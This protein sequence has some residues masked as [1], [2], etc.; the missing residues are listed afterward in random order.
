LIIIIILL[1]AFVDMGSTAVP[2][3][4]TD[5]PTDVGK[6]YATLQGTLVSDGSGIHVHCGFDYGLTTA[7]GTLEQLP[8]IYVYD[9]GFTTQKIRQFYVSNLSMI[10]ESADY[11]GGIYDCIADDQFVYIA[12]DGTQQVWQLWASNL[13][14]RANTTDYGGI[15]TCIIADDDYVYYA[16]YTTQ[17]VYQVWKNNMTVKAISAD[18]GG[19]INAITEDE[20]YIYIGGY[21]TQTVWQLW[22]T[23][24]TKKCETPDYGGTIWSVIVDQN[25][26]FNQDYI[27]VGGATTQRI[28]KYWKDN[29]TYVSQTADYGGQIR[30]IAQDD[31]HLYA[32]GTAVFKIFRYWKSNMTKQAETISYG[33]VIWEIASDST[34]PYIYAGGASTMKLW[35]LWR[36]NMTLKAES[37]SY[38]GN[39]RTVTTYPHDYQSGNTFEMNI[40]GLL[41]GTLYHYRAYTAN[42]FGTSYG[43]D[44]TFITD[45]DTPTASFNYSISGSNIIC[46]SSD[47]NTTYWSCYSWEI[48]IDGVST[49]STGWICDPSGKTFIYTVQRTCQVQITH[50]VKNGNLTDSIGRGLGHIS[51]IVDHPTY[52][53]CTTR[54]LCDDGGFYWY[55]DADGIYRCHKEQMT[56]PWNKKTLLPEA[57]YPAFPTIHFGFFTFKLEGILFFAL[58]ILVFLIV[59]TKLKEKGGQNHG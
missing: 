6:T 5:T 8:P 46:T 24:L 20:Y 29:G 34:C 2:I 21:T 31:E 13:T 45:F 1:G 36:D 15:I 7:Y 12:G 41:P 19:T 3:V 33:G 25:G 58:V 40:T 56:M 39:I 59:Y 11:G 57:S 47:V 52:Q 49:G 18:Y 30:A 43:A 9:A 38:G 16:G 55:Q 27:Y 50:Q 23:N 53:N 14:F 10:R 4:T 28:R 44:R 37:S 42:E 51:P 26:T 32:A 22:K 17:R 35:Q 48:Y 54:R